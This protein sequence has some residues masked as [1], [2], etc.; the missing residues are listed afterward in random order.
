LK[1]FPPERMQAHAIG[2]RIGSVKN[3]DA[4]LIERVSLA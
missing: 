3:D 1:P 2:L 4:A